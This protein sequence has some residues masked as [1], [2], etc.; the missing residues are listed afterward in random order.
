MSVKSSKLACS[1]CFKA[2]NNCRR[3]ISVSNEDILSILA[4]CS[5]FLKNILKNKQTMK[6][7]FIEIQK[8]N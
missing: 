8:T 5:L 4:V 6:N 3:I 7:E 2:G 1:C